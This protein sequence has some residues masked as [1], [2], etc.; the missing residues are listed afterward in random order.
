LVGKESAAGI[1]AGE[2]TNRSPPNTAL[3]VPRNQK[4]PE[5]L[6]RKGRTLYAAT[7]RQQRNFPHM[8]GTIL[9]VDDDAHDA[10]FLQTLLREG[11]VQN[12]IR[13]VGS[14]TEA[15]LYLQGDLQYGDREQFPL[16]GIIFLDLKM[17]GMDG[18]D[19]LQWLRSRDMLKDLYVFVVTG[20]ENT[21]L[22]QRAYA[23]GAKSFA[24][25]P[26]NFRDLQ[27]LIRAFPSLWKMKNS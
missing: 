1:A 24:Q 17:P 25:K 12:L 27:T 18:F 4:Y 20:L 22:I 11:G 15:I 19:F 21:A 7:K 26:Y 23:E 8:S 10:E 16:P 14:A 5:T 2:L 9:I 3:R 13:T 6:L